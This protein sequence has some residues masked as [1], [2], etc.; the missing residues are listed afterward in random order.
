MYEIRPINLGRYIDSKQKTH[1]FICFQWWRNRFDYVIDFKLII[2]PGLACTILHAFNEGFKD[3]FW[4]NIFCC[5]WNLL[6][7]IRNGVNMYNFWLNRNYKQIYL[8]CIIA[9]ES[10]F[11]HCLLVHKD[12]ICDEKIPAFVAIQ[13]SKYNLATYYC[14]I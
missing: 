4:S 14:L 10:A 1:Y 11:S 6:L 3:C 8:T 13:T 12:W 2:T 9:L 5:Y 7:H